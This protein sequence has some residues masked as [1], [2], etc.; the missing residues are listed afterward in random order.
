MPKPWMRKATAW[1]G[2]W[3]IRPIWPERRE[4]A[5]KLHITELIA[6][7]LYN[8]GVTDF[9]QGQK[10]L[11][12]SLSDL[13]DPSQLSN[14][15]VAV[16]RI[17][18]ALQN[19]EKI[20]IYGD[21]D[22]DG[23]TATATLWRCLKLAGI[24]VDTYV[25]HRI[26]EGY[27]LNSAAIEKLAE[28]GTKLIITVD[29]GIG[30]YQEAQLAKE[31][32]IDLIIT[33]HH[34]LEGVIPEVVAVIHPDLPGQ[35]YKN[36]HLCGA[37]VAFK[38][39]WAIAQGL[40]GKQKVTPEFRQFLLTATALVALGTIAD[41]V[42]LVG[43]NRILA[44]FGMQALAHSDDIGIKALLQ[45]AGLT[46]EKLQSS[47]IAF[48]LAPRLNAAGR[49]G[50]AMLA[51]ELFTKS[52]SARA[53]QIAAY[54]ESQ[55]KQRQ[56]VEK[57]VTEQ[58]KAQLTQLKMDKDD[59][60]GIVLAGENWHAGVVG[61]VAGKIA[62]QYKR[63]TV[64]LSLQTDKATGSCRSVGNFDICQALQACSEHLGTFGGHAMA[65]GVSLNPDNLQAFREA[66]NQYAVENLHT[67]DIV[68][69]LDI[70]AEIAI[71]QLDIKTVEMMQR[72]G[73]F[74]RA[75]PKIKLAARKLKLAQ[76]PRRIG[77]KGDH[78]QLV[79]TQ[80]DNQSSNYQPGS[81]IRAIAFNQ[82]KLEKKMLD[83]ASFDLAFQPTINRF[84]GNTTVEMIV[85]D[86]IIHDKS[87][88]YNGKVG[89]VEKV[90]RV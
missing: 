34:K 46:G 59:C 68:N 52:D 18:Q 12:P 78:L 89:K 58:A 33:D 25:P 48:R 67:D 44:K 2:Q 29:C 76:P 56:K 3:K 45:A 40:S 16:T 73:P 83:A 35:S 80:Q 66:F 72:L 47:D 11:Q 38:L 42:P 74:G 1:Q 64:V 39:A 55:N 41:V 43:E 21:Y 28:K 85:D 8:R 54:L 90:G 13:V 4:L 37:G 50:H 77:K 20:T 9:Q 88:T 53:S 62:D 60:R 69:T 5:T 49:M 31:L 79:V 10:F 19:N 75:N 7:L 24:E 15:T 32:G 26:D 84:N 6:Q 27:G 17:R 61:I 71:E 86:I 63:P 14:I 51:L 81:V 22:V 23:I 87:D 30:A 70:D 36:K 57:D 82:G 65:A